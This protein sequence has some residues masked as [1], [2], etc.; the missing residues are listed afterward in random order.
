MN[1]KEISAKNFV[2]KKQKHTNKQTIYI[3]NNIP[4]VPNTKK[5]E[6]T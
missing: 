2:K 5:Y 6:I 3:K 4:V 1:K